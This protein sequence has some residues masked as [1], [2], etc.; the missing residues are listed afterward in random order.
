MPPSLHSRHGVPCYW[1]L[2]PEARSI[3]VNVLSEGR[4]E[5]AA[6]VSGPE[7]VS[8]PPFPDLSLVPASLWP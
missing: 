5:L 6:R 3:E 1:I 4:Y 2:D 7:A 8:L